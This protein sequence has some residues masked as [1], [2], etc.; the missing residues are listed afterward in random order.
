MG[1]L[2]G[3]LVVIA[4]GVALMPMLRGKSGK[5]KTNAVT[6][7]SGSSIG[8]TFM[9]KAKVRASE[10]KS[11][12]P[13]LQ[14]DAAVSPTHQLNLAQT[15]V[16]RRSAIADIAGKYYKE[17]V[18]LLGIH[19]ESGVGKTV[20]ATQIAS[21]L[22]PRYPDAQFYIDLKTYSKHPVSTAEAMAQIIWA[23][24]PTARLPANPDDLAAMY[25]SV[26]RDQRAIILL[27]NADNAKARA[28]V[29]PKTCLFLAISRGPLSVPR[30]YSRKIDVLP[31]EESRELMKELAPRAEFWINEIGKICDNLPLAFSIIGKFLAKTVQLDPA[32]FVE[33]LRVLRE[34]EKEH[35]TKSG[36]AGLT[37]TLSLV[38]KFLNEQTALIWNKLQVFPGTFSGKAVEAICNDPNAL[39]LGHLVAIGLVE[40]NPESD[41]YFLHE[42]VRE[43]LENHMNKVEYTAALSKHAS[44][45]LTV[46]SA[47]NDFYKQG[48]EGVKKALNL[49]DKEWGN[50]QAGYAWAERF[51]GK[52]GTA[53]KLCSSYVETGYD[54]LKMRQRPNV[55]LKWLESALK[56]SKIT[57]DTEAEMSHLL[58]TGLEHSSQGGHAQS[59]DFFQQ[60]LELAKKLNNKGDEGAALRHLGIAYS[61]TG[62]T[63]RALEFHQKELDLA[64]SR[65]DKED[66]GKA[67]A[68]MGNTHK[69]AGNFSQAIEFF[70]QWLTIVQGAED[71]RTEGQALK[72]L[73]DTRMETENETVPILDLYLKAIHIFQTIKDRHAEA[74]V[75][76]SM[77]NAYLKANNFSSA[78]ETFEKALVV[79]R[80]SRDLRNEGLVLHGIGMVH[81]A[82][83][84]P[85]QAIELYLKA[86][87][88][89]QK[90]MDKR[91]QL[92]TLH[93]LARA[94]RESVEMDKAVKAYEQGLALA[95]EFLERNVEG[96]MLWEMSQ[97]LDILGDKPKAIS[98][99]EAAIKHLETA[100]DPE[101]E[102]VKKKI[103]EWKAQSASKG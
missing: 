45:F 77:G 7:S 87:A 22:A 34:A 17:E 76:R 23:Y 72:V 95:R 43:Y 98:Q 60:A 37:V 102:N 33:K 29:P 94:Y 62:D 30:M 75:L 51:L 64:R 90:T 13:A 18:T 68:S 25:L 52:D 35:G 36:Q 56:A 54:L 85:H 4:L 1:I 84:K 27:D 99:A 11:K 19:G 103:E 12:S 3:V 57:L 61:A 97:V 81:R 58:N 14:V 91:D 46:L 86:L 40:H 38:S 21:K 10:G 50:I 78:A 55:R 83:K 63:E 16:G 2:I 79:F 49:F 28:L 65:G 89:F 101:L 6:P 44:Y 5:E 71:K 41:R 100:K 66:E 9:E 74:V 93:Q 32:V 47:A 67:L 88:L 70:Q 69:R 80:K 8:A 96:Q 48:D 73:A 24:R 31:P 92:T 82:E 15:F 59:I 42:M 39:H 26:L 20:L 53:T